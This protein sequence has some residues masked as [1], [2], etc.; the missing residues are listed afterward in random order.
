MLC[1]HSHPAERGQR[2]RFCFSPRAQGIL[3]SSKC[4]LNVSAPVCMAFCQGLPSRE[5]RVHHGAL[6]W[7]T[8]L[9]SGIPSA[10]TF[11]RGW[12]MGA[13]LVLLIP[14][15]HYNRVRPSRERRSEDSAF[16][17]PSRRQAPN[18]GVRAGQRQGPSPRCCQWLCAGLTIPAPSPLLRTQA[19]I[20]GDVLRRRVPIPCALALP[21]CPFVRQFKKVCQKVL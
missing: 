15:G 16:E 17:D 5:S 13:I 4:T 6:N 10:S 7:W 11:S 1:H 19:Q 18:S 2:L 21:N 14:H 8:K 9:P 3:Y 20:V 12:Y